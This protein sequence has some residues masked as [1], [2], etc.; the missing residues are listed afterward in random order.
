MPRDTVGAVLGEEVVAARVEQG[1]DGR[2]SIG[3]GVGPGVVHA[4]RGFA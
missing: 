1:D 4:L 2:Y 3:R